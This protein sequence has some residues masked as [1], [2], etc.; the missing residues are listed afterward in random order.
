LIESLLF[1][2]LILFTTF[3]SL[4]TLLK[5]TVGLDFGAG[6]K[7]QFV[8]T[9]YYPIDYFYD[10]DVLRYSLTTSSAPTK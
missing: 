5:R 1:I 2:I 3:Y 8:D 10:I 6:L 7:G 9:G 4:I